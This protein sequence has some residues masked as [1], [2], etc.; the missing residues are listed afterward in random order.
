MTG[1]PEPRPTRFAG[2]DGVRAVAVVAVI[3]AHSGLDWLSGGGAGVSI[4][5]SLSGFLITLLLLRER[6]ETGAVALGRFWLRRLLR[7]LPALLL[8]LIAVDALV[9]V[10]GDRLGDDWRQAPGATVPALF[11]VYNWMLVLGAPTSVLSPL[12]SLSVEE[13]FYLVWPVILIVL[14]RRGAGLRGLALTACALGVAAAAARFALVDPAALHRTYGTDLNV[15]LLLGGALLAI[16]LR[17][18]HTRVVARVSG[19]AVIPAA[20]CLL[21][22][23]LFAR[24][25][26]DPGTETATYLYYTVGLP[27]ISL[28]TVVLVGFLVTHPTAVL[29]RALSIRPLAFAGRISYGMYLWHFPVLLAVAGVL[30][31]RPVEVVFVAALALTVAVASLSFFLVELPLQRRFQERLRAGSKPG[32][33]LIVPHSA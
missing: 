6:A 30:E 23:F 20:L 33:S 25:L 9:A 18:G 22:V 19:F 31:G 3:G 1:A 24:V 21:M 2:I 10:L 8:M 15:D 28:S 4:F 17:A 26:G 5:F 27:L 32:Q 29:T 13:Q 14:R 11:Y 16:G 7:L 12:W